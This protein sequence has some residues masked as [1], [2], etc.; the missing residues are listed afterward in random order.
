MKLIS[1]SI[2]R[3][4][5]VTMVVLA[6]LMFGAVS[7]T[8]LRINLL[9]E[10]TYPTLTIR[11]EYPGAAPA[12]VENLISKPIEESLGVVKNVRKISSISRSE[13]SD[14]TIEFAWGTNMDF[15]GLEVREKI[16]QLFLPTDS[17]RPSILKYDPSLD[18]I[19]RYGFFYDNDTDVSIEKLRIFADEEIKKALEVI[20]GV[21]SV[22][23]SGGLEDEIHVLIDQ[24]KLARLNLDVNTI[25]SR[26]A[27]ENINYSGG[28]LE[29]GSTRLLV[30][31]INEFKTIDEI[32]DISIGTFEGKNLKLRDVAE[33]RKSYKDRS[34]VTRVDGRESVEIAIYKEGDAN[35]VNVAKLVNYKIESLNKILPKKTTFKKV[36]DQSIFIQN[37]I[38]EVI[39]SGIIGGLLAIIILY[40]FLKN[41]WITLV[42]SF[43]IPVSVIATFNLMYGNNITLNIMSLGGITLGIGML[44]DNSIVV[45]E[46]ISRHRENGMGI[47][48]SAIKGAREVGTA[49]TA[50]TLTT[51][52]VFF[53]LIFVDG[54]AG[55]LFRDQAMTV[56]FSLVASLIVSL[57]LVPMLASIVRKS[58]TIIEEDAVKNGKNRWYYLIYK[59]SLLII[60]KTVFIYVPFGIVFLV[61]RVFRILSK[62]MKIIMSPFLM[63]FD[64]LFGFVANLYPKILKFSL[65]HPVVVLFFAILMFL[66]SLSLVPKL[67]MELIPQ[68]TQGEFKAEIKLTAGS[69][70]AKTDEVIKEIQN[71]FKDNEFIKTMYSV[72]GTGNLLTSSTEE[73]GENK[74]EINFVLKS[75]YL[76]KEDFVIESVRSE[77]SRKAGLE[78]KF[79]KPALF[80]F[81]TPL[82]IEIS[83]FN[84]NSLKKAN[85]DIMEILENDPQ[86][87]DV[88]T[89]V[90]RGQPEIQVFFDREKAAAMNLD[91][92]NVASKITGRIKGNLATKFTEKDRKIDIIVK[93]DEKEFQSVE[94]VKNMII[95]PES[96]T[97]VPLSSIATIEI[98]DSPVEIRRTEQER[99]AIISAGISSGDLGSAA[100]KLK[101]IV[102]KMDFPEG[103]SVTIAGQ[104]EEMEASFS[105]LKFT[106]LM[107]VFLVYLVM[108]SQF[109]S[110]IHPFVIL[111]S[112]PLALIGAVLALYLTGYPL[113]VVVF[114]GGILLAGIVVNNAI[115]LIDLVN[116]L[117]SEGMEKDE[118][119]IMGGSRRL[120][121]IL[122]TTLTT[123]LG[124]LPM[125]IG[126]G[127]GAELRAPMGVTVIGGLV[128]STLLTLIIIPVVYKL[129]DRKKFDIIN[130]ESSL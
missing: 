117:R 88:K 112:I 58:E 129:I 115:V 25:A 24:G 128:M 66:G 63:V 93:A 62:S 65:N 120:R 82:E 19:M 77:L 8:R 91:I 113:S 118:A 122:M 76:D 23:I 22:K 13:Q 103:I 125:S 110:F 73:G 27:Y 39:N 106:L 130:Q 99:V 20:D 12:E 54:I 60:F 29:E 55:Q 85:A 6:V 28:K 87:A 53:P 31:T 43:S 97:P 90:D 37:S 126:L 101:N 5:T 3:K 49:V 36:Y 86:F 30:R 105:S 17:K 68:M 44:L 100:Q 104:N 124:L 123:V 111:F 11:T 38:D 35:A 96:K 33:I 81:K 2:K 40:F 95:N 108:A 107:A 7:F 116:Q 61:S 1:I 69:P 119:L 34:A 64:K 79:T 98:S 57:T 59:Y 74:G 67:G 26:L 94:D 10:L 47:V 18:P 92:E 21:A 32:N 78:Y 16:D 14:V 42:T 70:L 121:S 4:V 72:A 75:E 71:K 51:I 114:I 15:A 102:R 46:N 52:A 80:S 89:T 41:F 48:E 9:P 127:E 56:T 50:S 45:L 109:E 83:G 84:I